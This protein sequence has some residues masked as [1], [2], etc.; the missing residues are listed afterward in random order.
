MGAYSTFANKG[1][2]TKPHFITKIE[3]RNGNT[4]VEFPR[5]RRQE[6]T[7]EMAYVMLHMLMGATQE[8][9]GTA[10]GLGRFGLLKDNQVGAKTGTTQNHSDGWFMGGTKGL[11]NGGWVGG[12]DRSIHFRT[13]ALGQGARM[14]MPI[15]ALYMQ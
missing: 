9:H 1:V 2:Y 3:D 11:V 6:L 15:W 7:E 14:T 13:L 4:I 5:E 8:K 12:D 10:L